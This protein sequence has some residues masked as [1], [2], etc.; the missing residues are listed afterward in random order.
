MVASVAL[1]G[2]DIRIPFNTRKVKGYYHFFREIETGYLN[3]NDAEKTKPNIFKTKMKYLKI[4]IQQS[5]KT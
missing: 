5:V 2:P 1:S 3:K 4:G